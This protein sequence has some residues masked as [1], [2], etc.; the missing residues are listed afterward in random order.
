MHPILTSYVL[1]FLHALYIHNIHPSHHH[2]GHG[3]ANLHAHNSHKHIFH[4]LIQLAR[5]LTLCFIMLHI[6]ISCTHSLTL[7]TCV[8]TGCTPKKSS[9]LSPLCPNGLR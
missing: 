1:S 8:D 2:H 5:T 4:T 9:S 6:F 7:P 3:L